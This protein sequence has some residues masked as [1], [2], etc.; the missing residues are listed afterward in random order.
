MDRFIK[1]I[2]TI[3]QVGFCIYLVL[4]IAF[5]LKVKPHTQL[6]VLI[7][8]FSIF[9]LARLYYALKKYGKIK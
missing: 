8:Y 2:D 9:L 3:N 4:R 1:V 5:H 7:I 6:A